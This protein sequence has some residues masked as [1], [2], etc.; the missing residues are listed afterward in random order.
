MRYILVAIFACIATHIQPAHGQGQAI[1][2]LS[3]VGKW[4][5]SERMANGAVLTTDLT[6]TQTQKFSGT[7]TVHGKEFWSYSGSWEVTN[8]ELIWH[9]ENS[10]R[11]LP[12]SAKNDIDNIIS[13]D[14]EKLIL[15]SRL[16]S[17][18]QVYLR[19]S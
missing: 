8:G 13:V 15:A 7:A 4:S 11:P 10:S 9:Y 18:Q 5:T 14:A 2:P 6:L 12:E 1:S 16:S 3:L 17:K 19:K